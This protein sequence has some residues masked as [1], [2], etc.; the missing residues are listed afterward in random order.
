MPGLW[1]PT[2]S[3]SF[4][5]PYENAYEICSGNIKLELSEGWKCEMMGK[6]G[7]ESARIIRPKGS[8]FD[9]NGLA[10]NSI[11]KIKAKRMSYRERERGLLGLDVNGR[12][13]GSKTYEK[14]G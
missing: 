11:R 14:S 2:R 1:L 12:T 4:I 8:N 3:W 6:V 7:R 5:S 10:F 9:A 13:A